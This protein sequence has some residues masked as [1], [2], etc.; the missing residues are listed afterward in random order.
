VVAC[1]YK[2]IQRCHDLES[3][4]LF[5]VGEPDVVSYGELQQMIGEILHGTAW[6]TVEIPKSLAKV[7]AWA[8]EK[9]GHDT[10]IKPWMIDLADAHYPI[11]VS[12]A[13]KRLGWL[14][15]HF[16]RDTVPE[17]ARRLRED[18]ARWY[19]ANKLELPEWLSK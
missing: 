1:I 5:L 10:F 18:P 13:R 14:P 6:S 4:E 11:D 9:V 19:R 3:E 17:M 12:R 15:K 16:L 8:E 7:G 2:V